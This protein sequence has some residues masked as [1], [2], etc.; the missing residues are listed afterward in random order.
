MLSL[1]TTF[2][3]N[4]QRQ[5]TELERARAE[6]LAAQQREYEAQVKLEKTKRAAKVR[7]RVTAFLMMTAALVK[8]AW[9]W[10]DGPV[11]ATATSVEKLITQSTAAILV[12]TGVRPTE[13]EAALLRLHDAFIT[14]PEQDAQDVVQEVNKRYAGTEFTCSLAWNE[15]MPA[16]SVKSSAGNPPMLASAAN[17]CAAGVE[18][19]RRE[20]DAALEKPVK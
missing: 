6:V 12:K 20:R 10:N 13:S 18:R 9:N 3:E 11:P 15:G 14:L 16:L 7:L 17:Q 5:P 8:L 19:L 2:R 4:G 1:R